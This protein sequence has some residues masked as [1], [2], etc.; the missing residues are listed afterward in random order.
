MHEETIVHTSEWKALA[1]H[2]YKE[3]M[4]TSKYLELEVVLQRIKEFLFTDNSKQKS[5]LVIC[6]KNSGEL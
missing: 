4:F 3:F 5:D 1:D 2:F 6:A